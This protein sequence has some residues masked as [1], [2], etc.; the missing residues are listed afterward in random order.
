[1]SIAAERHPRQRI[2]GIEEGLVVWRFYESAE[3]R[4][5]PK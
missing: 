1:M 4:M 2:A 3:Q 5:S